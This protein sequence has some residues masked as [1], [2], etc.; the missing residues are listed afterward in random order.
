MVCSEE[1][2]ELHK[3][4]ENM[5]KVLITGAKGQLGLALQKELSESEYE[6]ITTDVE[7][8]DITNI[9]QVQAF[10][11]EKQPDIIINCAAYTAVDRCEEKEEQDK[12]YQI[13][14]LGP[15]NLSIAAEEIGA[16]M[17]Q[18][19][20]DYVFDGESKKPYDE[21]DLPNPQS[22]YGR[23]KLAGEEFVKEFCKKHFIVRTAWLYGEGKNF[24]KTMVS[25][26]K[27]QVP[28]K[29]V[30]DQF[31]SPTSARA[32]AAMIGKLIKTS[33]YGTYH[34]TCEGVTNWYEFAQEIFKMGGL[35][36]DLSPTT[37][38][39][40]KSA[41]KRPKYSVLEKKMYRLNLGET[42]PHWKEELKIY[43]A[44]LEE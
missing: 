29:V 8:L 34:G 24:V 12:V 43:M 39:E 11:K 31:G 22:V 32:L 5:K 37:S 17:V 35:E 2:T 14:A 25:L 23:S 30:N 19:S 18:V 13:N 40:Y 26:A 7:E 28:I 44:N 41:A 4:G 6:Q 21:F 15:R 27:K 33:C 9:A 38:E 10:I 42:M 3:N 16:V 1:Y 20:T 36:V